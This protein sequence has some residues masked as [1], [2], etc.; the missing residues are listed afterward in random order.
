MMSYMLKQQNV[1]GAEWLSAN[2]EIV[3]FLAEGNMKWIPRI[4]V[5]KWPLKATC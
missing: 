3:F 2:R 4:Q 5:G 1:G